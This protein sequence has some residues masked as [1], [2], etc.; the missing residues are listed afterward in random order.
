[1]RKVIGVLSS[2]ALAAIL[3]VTAAC[4]GSNQLPTSAS[5]VSSAPTAPAPTPPATGNATG[6]ATITGMLSGV[7]SSSNGLQPRAITITVTITGTNISATASPGSTFVLNGV[8]SGHVE[9]HF[10][11]SGVDARNAIEDVAENEQIHIVVNVRGT[12]AQVDVDSREGPNHGTELEGLIA[13]IN[14]S[15]RTMVVN[16]QTVS[17]PTSAVIRHGDKPFTLAELLVGQRVHV[18]GTMNGSTLVATEVML[19]DENVNPP[20]R[21]DEAEVEGAV[22]G[23]SGS[24]PSIA[25]TVQ[26]THVSTSASTVFEKGTCAQVANGV[27]VSVKGSRQTDGSI[28]A[29]RVELNND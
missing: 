16:G 12:T 20:G 28:K 26:S 5:T 1:M 6:S 22:S 15:A 21:E 24:C 17:V 29:T 9:L 8:P 11:G 2:T 25:F 23:L 14:I 19:Q 13:S 10:L 27:K 18:K 7:S 3:C 4:N